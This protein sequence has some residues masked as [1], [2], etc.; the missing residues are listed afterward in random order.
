MADLFWLSDE[1]WAVIEPFMPKDQPG[2]ERKDDRQRISLRGPSVPASCTSRHRAAAGAT[3]RRQ[4]GRARPSTTGSIGRP[5]AAPGRPCWQIGPRPGGRATQPPSTAPLCGPIAWLTAAKGGESTGI[6]CSRGGQTTKIHALTDVFGRRPRRR[7]RFPMLIASKPWRP[8]NIARHRSLSG[9]TFQPC[10]R[11][12]MEAWVA[13]LEVEK[14][15]LGDIARELPFAE[16]ESH[17]SSP[18]GT[19]RHELDKIQLDETGSK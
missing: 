10:L 15:V 5:A 4:A 7:L 13:A 6:G 11:R 18:F 14:L 1:Q 8:P 3:A 2:P 19:R 9:V 16:H 17:L 12:P